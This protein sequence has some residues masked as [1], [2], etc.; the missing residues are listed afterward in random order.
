MAAEREKIE[1]ERRAVQEAREKAEREEFERQAK[2]TAEREAKERAE[3]ERIEA[4]QERIRE[5]ERKAAEAARIEALRPD[6]EKVTLFAKKLRDIEI[7][8]V[9]DESVRLEL[10]RALIEIGQLADR[11][12][13][14][15]D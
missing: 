9:A 5:E 4:E 1:V 7:P 10:Y 14:L 15:A 13:A 8:V 12:E 6:I 2:I 3:Q 11:L